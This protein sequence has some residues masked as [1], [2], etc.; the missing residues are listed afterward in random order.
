MTHS[1]VSSRQRS[2]FT[3][4]ELLV[5][6]AI[7]AVLIGLLLPAVQKVREAAMRMQ[8]TNN[9][10]QLALAAIA[11]Q[12]AN[13]WMPYN[14]S[15]TNASGV[16]DSGSW[17]Y[18]ILPYIEQQALFASQTSTTLPSSWNTPISTFLN[19]LRPRPGFFSGNLVPT[20]TAVINGTT[21]TAEAGTPLHLTIP[22]TGGISL[23][24]SG[25]GSLSLSESGGNWIITI[26]AST[27]TTITPDSGPATDFGINPFINSLPTTGKAASVTAAVGGQ[28]NAANAHRTLVQ[29][30]DGTSNTILL[31][32]MYCAISNYGAT[33]PTASTDLPI[34]VPGTLATARN[35]NGSSATT[36]LQDGT[37]STSNQWGS[38]LSSG[39]LMSMADGSVHLIPYST[40]LTTL[41]NP[42]DGHPAIE[43]P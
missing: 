25:S 41:I 19:P 40:P 37:A 22:A 36:W 16:V 13:G 4:V 23:S 18:Q 30:P 10:K 34:F 9:Q 38:P 20:V 5:V 15:S 2:G 24:V 12:D 27:S 33:T 21:Y 6:I 28:V 17:A 29:I 35:G 8:A 14:G 11:F 7:I 42:N 32:D 3:L 39:G 31:G 26:T 1:S 43:L